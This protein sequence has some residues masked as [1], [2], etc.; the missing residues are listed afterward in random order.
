[1]KEK[2]KRETSRVIHVRPYTLPQGVQRL[3]EK[4]KEVRYRSL[5][6]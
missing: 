6:Y 4:E 5:T 3:L 2:K 1:M